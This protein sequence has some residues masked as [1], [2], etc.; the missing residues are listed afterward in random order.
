LFGYASLDIVE[1]AAKKCTGNKRHQ[2]EYVS[3]SY[4]AVKTSKSRQLPKDEGNGLVTK[5]RSFYSRGT[6]LGE[7]DSIEATASIRSISVLIK[8]ALN[9]Y[10]FIPFSLLFAL[11]SSRSLMHYVK[12]S[13]AAHTKMKSE[14][15]RQCLY[16]S[17]RSSSSPLSPFVAS[18]CSSSDAIS[19]DS[20]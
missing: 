7:G 11:S 16:S 8:M 18:T 17:S 14:I 2:M 13:C 3:E 12:A 5:E 1:E 10:P 4:G 20:V 19:S 9:K 15:R 6:A